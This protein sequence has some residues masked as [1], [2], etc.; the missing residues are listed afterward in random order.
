VSEQG[1]LFDKSSDA[2][3]VAWLA[4]HFPTQD[5]ESDYV[6]DLALA[7]AENT[8][9]LLAGSEYWPVIQ[10]SK[11][12][13][14]LWL[15]A[16]VRAYDTFLNHV[17][18]YKWGF[19]DDYVLFL[20]YEFDCQC[21]EVDHQSNLPMIVLRSGDTSLVIGDVDSIECEQ[22]VLEQVQVRYGNLKLVFEDMI[23]ARELMFNFYR[24]PVGWQKRLD[25][26]KFVRYNHQYPLWVN[27]AKAFTWFSELDDLIGV[28][29]VMPSAGWLAEAWP[30]I[31]TSGHDKQFA[32]NAWRILKASP[33][34]QLITAAPHEVV[35][36][37]LTLRLS[38][39]GFLEIVIDER[40]DREVLWLLESFGVA[41]AD[42]A[43]Y[44]GLDTVSDED[45]DTLTDAVWQAVLERVKPLAERL[46]AALEPDFDIIY[47][48]SDPFGMREVLA[49]KPLPNDEER[50]EDELPIDSGK[51]FQL[52]SWIDALFI[53]ISI[54]TN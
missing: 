50:L 49:G 48:Y 27:E 40:D 32:V 8:W 18:G 13:A 14:S 36:W 53:S 17:G 33:L 31:L 39:G 51:V 24:D 46:R 38:Y 4:E 26:Q 12:E 34:W 30:S 10:T 20:A 42:M 3:D 16:I 28:K 6:A 41:G 5:F 2:F 9:R 19:D 23:G 1:G 35:L 47:F 45:T 37:A 7:F 54:L 15:I 25:G 43:R 29:Y 44:L 11:L 22:A 52:W 21:L